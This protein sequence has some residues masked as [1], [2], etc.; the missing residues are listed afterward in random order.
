MS[1]CACTYTL[2]SSLY[3]IAHSNP[4]LLCLCVTNRN[5]NEDTEE[6]EDEEDEEEDESEEDESE[7]E[8]QRDTGHSCES[9]Y[10]SSFFHCNHSLLHI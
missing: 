8:E 9:L 4:S 7:D 5:Y 1:V 10:I 3:T 6:E 2:R